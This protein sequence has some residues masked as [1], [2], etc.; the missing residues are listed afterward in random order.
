MQRG[1]SGAVTGDLIG[2]ERVPAFADAAKNQRLRLHIIERRVW[3]HS[4]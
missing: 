3:L 2:T 1:G 4:Q